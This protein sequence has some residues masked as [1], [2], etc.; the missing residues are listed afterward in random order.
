MRDYTH[1]PKIN[2][3][4]SDKK[5]DFINN[6]LEK[7]EKY[8]NV[9]RKVWERIIM[10]I[11]ENKVGFSI[12]GDLSI[13]IQNNTDFMLKEV[14]ENLSNDPYIGTMTNQLCEKD[15][16]CQIEQLIDKINKLE[17]PISIRMNIYSYD[18]L[19]A[20]I[21]SKML[22]CFKNLPGLYIKIDNQMPRGLAE[23]IY[24]NGRKKQI[25]LFIEE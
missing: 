16:Q 22:D 25:Q 7:I 17:Y 14:Y 5:I 23:I 9:Q 12:K 21:D 4:N 8:E 19:K 20:N 11:R 24:N 10:D 18:I 1:I 2:I 3:F 13:K 6:Q 15:L